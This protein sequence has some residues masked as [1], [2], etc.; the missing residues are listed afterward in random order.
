MQENT[1][2]SYF[3]AQ[4]KFQFVLMIIYNDNVEV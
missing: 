3:L 1:K 2:G 4:N